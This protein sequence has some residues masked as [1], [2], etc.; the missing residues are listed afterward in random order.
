M[1][2]YA[3]FWQLMKKKRVSQYRLIHEGKLSAGLINRLRK[4]QP[5]STESLRQI[6]ML[7]SCGVS[8]IVECLI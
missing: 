5:V 7:F 8:D 6:C 3:P 4:N 1:I 2:S